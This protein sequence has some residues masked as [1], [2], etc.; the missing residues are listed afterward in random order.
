MAVLGC[1]FVKE[2]T[3]GI[4]NNTRYFLKKSRDVSSGAGEYAIPAN[5]RAQNT[6]PKSV[7]EFFFIIRGRFLNLPEASQQTNMII[8]KNA[9]SADE[10][11]Q[12]KQVRYKA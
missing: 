4:N 9:V 1:P 6:I 5:K 11:K 3:I 12:V 7:M 2:S 8:E 10:N